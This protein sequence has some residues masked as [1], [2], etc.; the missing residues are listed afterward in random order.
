M[1][2]TQVT[3]CIATHKRGS[4]LEKLLDSLVT[5]QG[6]PP[7]DVIVVDN[8]RERSAEVVALQFRDKLPLTYLVEPVRGI[9]RTADAIRR[10]SSALSWSNS[11]QKFPKW[12]A[13]VVCLIAIGVRTAVNFPITTE[14]LAMPM[15]DA[16]RCLNVRRRFRRVWIC[17][18]VRMSTF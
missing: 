17:V 7:F 9:T 11:I 18:A 10:P 2:S 16:M 12:C 4:G 3:V 6:A 5:Q 8:D 14:A 13:I 15:S 1:S